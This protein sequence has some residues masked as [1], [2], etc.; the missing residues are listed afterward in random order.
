MPESRLEA[1]LEAVKSFPDDPFPRYGLA[2]E[3]KSLGRREEAAD[4][5][6]QL[7]ESHP[8]YVPAYLQAGMLLIE[9]GS[10]DEARTVLTRGAEVAGRAG[11][12]HARGEILDALGGIA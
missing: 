12:G 8:D 5:L 3:Y 6:R 7:L 10:T 2:L 11:N 9:L 1:L 4:V